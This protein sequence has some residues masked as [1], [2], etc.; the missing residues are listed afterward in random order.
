MSYGLVR[1]TRDMNPHDDLAS[2]K[3]LLEALGHTCDQD[4]S[5]GFKTYV[6]VREFQKKE[7]LRA[8]GVVGRRTWDALI[9]AAERPFK[10][11]SAA[12]EEDGAEDEEE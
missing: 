3:K 6:A 5:F 4:D 11:S 12:P 7:G 2:A 9:E 10:A 1:L 8:D